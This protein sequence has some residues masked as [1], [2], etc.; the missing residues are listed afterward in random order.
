MELLFP[1][2]GAVFAVTLI[3]HGL[4]LFFARLLR[5]LTQGEDPLRPIPPAGDELHELTVTSRMARRLAARGDLDEEA[6]ERLLQAVALRQEALRRPRR[7]ARSVPAVARARP[8]PVRDEDIPELELV[9]EVAS[10]PLVL[11]VAPQVSPPQAVA[12]PLLVPP[13]P[14]RRPWSDLLAGFMEARNILW[15]ELVGGLLI[16]GCS[17]ALVVTLWQTLE[18]I[19][20]F[21]FLV[22][23]GISLALFGVG[24]YTLHHWKLASTSRGLLAIATLLVPLNL[25]VLAGLSRGREGGLLETA[26]TGIGLAVFTFAVAGAGRVLA[27]GSRW[28]LALGVVGAAASQL[29][30][31][32]LPDSTAWLLVLPA[33]LTVGCHCSAVA[34]ACGNFAEK[35]H[36]PPRPSLRCCCSSAPL[37]LRPPSPWASC[38]RG[39]ATCGRP[40]STWAAAGRGGR[41]APHDGSCC[42]AG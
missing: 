41:A 20:Y 16:V 24:H 42:N 38:W 7:V 2:L 8:T 1:L 26:T 30:V 36:S 40:S 23:S 6:A 9:P 31:P 29:L 13:A 34:P 5:S 19:P 4:W 27:P 28:L 35:G 11:T 39:P 3:G 15:G 32:R 12:P 18:D 21:P 37:C 17:A 25:L 33:W 14:P 22:L 10:P